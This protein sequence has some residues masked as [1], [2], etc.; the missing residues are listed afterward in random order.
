MRTCSPSFDKLGQHHFRSINNQLLKGYMDA[1]VS[2]SGTKPSGV[3]FNTEEVGQTAVE[4]LTA[5][6][7]FSRYGWLTSYQ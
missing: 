3:V 7:W 4:G 5:Q 1:A 2:K 6:A